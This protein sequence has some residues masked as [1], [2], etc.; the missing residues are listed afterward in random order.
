[1]PPPTDQQIR[2]KLA[3]ILKIESACIYVALLSPVWNR[4]VY[5]VESNQPLDGQ[6]NP[7]IEEQ[8]T[9]NRE[10]L[11]EMLQSIEASSI[12]GEVSEIVVKLGHKNNKPCY[13]YVVV[14]S[15]GNYFI[16]VYID[17]PA[18]SLSQ[19][20]MLNAIDELRTFMA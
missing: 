18:L 13:V 8:I 6:N 14:L 17:A 20:R 12:K 2:K 9:K 1:M 5:V 15:S 7:T 3:D 16:R 4:Y 11:G 10:T 19:A